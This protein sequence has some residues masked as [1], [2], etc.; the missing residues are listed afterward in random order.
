[1]LPRL[2]RLS[3]NNSNPSTG[4]FYALTQEEAESN[5]NDPIDLEPLPFK[6]GSFSRQD[7]DSETFRIRS[8]DRYDAQWRLFLLLLPCV[9]SVGSGFERCQPGLQS[10]YQ[11][12]HLEG[13]LD[14]A[15]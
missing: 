7:P 13:R 3:L 5:G 1:M 11:R 14:P 6:T 9:V 8:V 4:K 10:Q 12:S 15:A 2:D